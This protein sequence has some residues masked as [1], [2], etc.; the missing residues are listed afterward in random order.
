MNPK[1]IAAIQERLSQLEAEKAKLENRLAELQTAG[2]SEKDEPRTNGPVTNHS[3]ASEKIA[4]FRSLFLG[5]EDVFPKRWQ[6][7]RAGKAG[8]APACGN[9][10][11][12]GICGKPKVKCG[13]CPNQDFLRVTDEVV[14]WHLRG[15]QTIGV[16]PMLADG[17]CWFLAADF[18]K[19][20]WQR[21]AEAFLATCRL[22]QIPSALERS[23]SGNGGHVWIFFAE[24]VSV[25]LARRLGAHLLTETMKRNPDIGFDSYDR[26][27]PSQDTMPTGGFGNLIALPL[28]H[29]PRQNGNSVFLNESFEPYRDQWAFLS[30]LSRLS[31]AKLMALVEVARR[32]DQVI[33][34]RRPHDE[35]NE[36]PWDVTPSRLKLIPEI[37][38]SLPRSL[39]VVLGNQIYIPRA[40]LPP[41]LINQLIRLAAFQNPAF[42]RAQAMR[43]STFGISRI[44][45]CGELLPH[46]IALP[47]GSREEMEQ[48]FKEL[49]IRVNLR[50]ERYSGHQIKADFLGELTSEQEVSADALLAHETGVMAAST[51][52]GKTVVAAFIIAAR[53]TNTLILVHRRQLMEQW[54]ARLSV[55]LDLPASSIGQIGG[56]KRQPTGIVDVAVIQ[57]MVRKGEVDDVISDY[58]H[59]VVDEC[60]HISAVSFEAV[61]R[62]AKA[63]YVLGLS[64]TVTRK[65]GHHP[66]IFMQ[67]GPVRFRTTAKAQARKRAFKHRVVL[68]PT[69]FQ[70]SAEIGEQRIPVQR[71]YTALSK[72]ETRNMLIFDDVL[73]TLDEQ[74]SP[75]IITE[76]KDHAF[77]LSERLSRFARNVLLLHGGMGVRQRREILQRLEEVPETEERVL[78]ATGRY[79]GEGFDD[80]RLDTLFL[81]MPVSWKGVLAQYVGRLHRPNPEKREVLVYDYVDNLV[82]MLKRMSEK[83]L[84]GYE[85]LGYLVENTNEGMR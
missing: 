67:C 51:A 29:G 33:D 9:E 55:F 13:E 79:I 12:P 64:A 63:K 32:Q 72:D 34:L 3:E 62:Y 26:L 4:L 69:E 73:K 31:L 76:R 45:S 30:T 70:L 46:H 39:D 6:N 43:L 53:K 68:R 65:D 15:R 14:D 74:R 44:I 40:G 58:G 60:H 75:V 71:I 11:K 25:A 1:E 47:R 28:Q 82:P 23:R 78:I 84:R 7:A 8:Y 20:T 66:I 38:T 16:Y 50:D 21:D 77:R 37:T 17:D 49:G 35:E 85:N 83:R 41:G 52:F 56:G 81:V 36:E 24:P 19:Q 48:L 54:I 2:A 5:R 18:D 10:W 22:K 57:S 27:F 42:Y 80:A 61:S 59:L